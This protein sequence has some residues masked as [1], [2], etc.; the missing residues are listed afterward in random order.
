MPAL[1]ARR[2]IRNK[3][4]VPAARY[5]GGAQARDRQ[6]RPRLHFRYNSARRRAVPRRHHDV[7]GEA[8][9]SPTSSRRW[10]STSSRRASRSRREGDF[11]AVSEIAK[12][13]K[14][15]GGVRA[16]ARGRARHRPRRRG[17]EA[18]RAAAHPHLPLHLARASQ[19]QAAEVGRAGAG[20]GALPG[21]AA[22]ATGCEDVEWSRGGRH[23]HRDRLP[24]PLRG[25][26][27]SR[28]APPPSTCPI[29]W[30]T[31]RPRNTSRCSAR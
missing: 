25:D 31:P 9:R 16:V 24:V 5:D 18:R 11:Y 6:H 10:A 30:A 12:R 4:H 13:I 29:R 27:A 23:P 19:A 17:G 3:A 26:R 22:R 15:V 7:R 8:A 1:R 21:H 2:L 14:N 20:D 28:P